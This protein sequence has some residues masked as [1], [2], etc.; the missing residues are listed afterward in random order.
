M[1]VTN[2][3]EKCQNISILILENEH[4]IEYCGKY[5]KLKL[6]KPALQTQVLIICIPK[7]IHVSKF[8]IL[9]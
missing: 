1:H 5:Q 4:E 8:Q 2:C 9:I 6:F 7:E 3:F